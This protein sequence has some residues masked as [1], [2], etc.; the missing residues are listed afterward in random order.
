MKSKLW[1]KEYLL[2]IAIL[3]FCHM[4][5]YLLISVITIFGKQLTGS[6]TYAGMLASVFAFAGLFARFISAW[7]LERMSCKK[8][9]FISVFILLAA[10]FGYVF[11]NSYWMAFILRGFQGF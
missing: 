8:V 5:P 6:D 1:T 7:L 2:T 11:A 10:S 3:M 9:M 4:G